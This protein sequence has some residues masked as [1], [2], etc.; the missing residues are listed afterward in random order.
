M[1]QESLDRHGALIRAA[2]KKASPPSVDDILAMHPPASTRDKRPPATTAVTSSKLFLR[3][4]SSESVSRPGPQDAAQMQVGN[5]AG[6]RKAG[7]TSPPL[8]RGSEENVDVRELNAM[9]AREAKNIFEEYGAVLYCT[10]FSGDGKNSMEKAER[11]VAERRR[12]QVLFESKP[13]FSALE[14]NSFLEQ[15]VN[16]SQ[17][18]LVNITFICL[19]GGCYQRPFRTGGRLRGGSHGQV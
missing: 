19:K 2:N 8:R 13:T 5:D 17:I 10:P 4:Q 9:L 14:V 3:R 16:H 1:L 11:M 15:Q 6:E 7:V 12:M 18:T